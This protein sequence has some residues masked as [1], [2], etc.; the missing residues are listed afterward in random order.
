MHRIAATFAM[1]VLAQLAWA[2]P[3]QNGSFELGP[4]NPCNTFNVPQGDTRITGWVISVGNIDWESGPP[5]G[6]DPSD[7]SN[8]LDLV[9]SGGIGGIQQTFDTIPGV[10]YQVQFDLAGNYGAP[11]V[12]KPLDV[13]INGQTTSFT[14]DTTGKSAVNMGWTTQTISFTAASSSSTINFVSDV[15]PS[16]GTLNAGAALDNVRVTGGGPG[17]PLFGKAFGASTISVGETT[18]LTFAIF[19]PNDGGI[20]GFFFTDPLPDGLVVAAPNGLVGDCGGGTVD[21]VSGSSSISLSNGFVSGVASCTFSVNVTATTSG[22]KNNTTSVLGYD[23]GSQAGTASASITVAANTAPPNIAKSFGAVTMMVGESTSLSFTITNPNKTT[24]LT[25]VGFNDALPGGLVVA[26]P[27]GLAGSCG[28][29]AIAATA[30]SGAVT[31]SGATLA[32]GATCAFSVNVTATAAG[33][34]NNTTDAVSSREGGNGNMASATIRVSASPPPPPPP[35]KCVAPTITSGSLPPGTIGVPYAFT[36]TAS[37]DSPLV[38]SVSG[39]PPGLAFDPASGKISGVPT[40]AGTSTLTITA[41]NGC[42]PSAVQ[43][44]SLTVGKAPATMTLAASPNP[45]YFGQAVTVVAHVIAAAPPAQGT[46][47]LCAREANAFCPPPFDT[48]PPGTPASLIRTPLSAPLDANSQAIFVLNGLTINNYVL[49]A[50]YSGDPTHIAA[51]A[52]PIDQFVIKGV[53]LAPPKVALAAPLHASSGAPLSIGVRVTPV[54]PAPIPTGTVSLYSGGNLVGSATLDAGG[55]TQFN[56]AAATTGT[57]PLRADYSGDALFP[58]A[59][60]PQSVV[61]I[62]A[63]DLTQEIPAVGPIGLAL[64]ALA[65]AAL[66]MRPLYRHARRR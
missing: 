49:K 14:F 43:T 25:G 11:P 63:A 22:V 20:G 58:P 28:G 19:N 7:G 8:S 23:D 60:S 34:Q 55:S 61:T 27:S 44:Q 6:W 64:L 12:V 4:P 21:A 42:Q 66:G 51:S 36:I 37:G 3:F 29:G 48:V 24:T 16:G 62:A 41:S 56:I 10:T 18:S 50:T 45:A 46:V 65:L 32:P 17:T 31:L 47:L 26:T 59:T 5:C 30:G 2:A 15:R 13:I 52:G 33:T 38:L 39:L 35:P 9:G 57:L 54:S 1:F 40:A 53:L